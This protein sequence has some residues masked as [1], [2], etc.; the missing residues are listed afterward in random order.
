MIATMSTL[1]H[2]MTSGP[3]LTVVER[4]VI[5]LVVALIALGIVILVVGAVIYGVLVIF[6]ILVQV[7]SLPFS[8]RPRRNWRL[9][10]SGPDLSPPERPR[11]KHPTAC[12]CV[13]CLDNPLPPV[14]TN[15]P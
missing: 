15:G 5:L 8:A 13:V 14:M 4:W 6:S 12:T 9:S 1:W 11:R 2:G 3:W 7:V 10:G